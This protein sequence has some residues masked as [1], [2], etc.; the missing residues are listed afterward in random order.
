LY[1]AVYTE[2]SE[3]VCIP[4][5]TSFCD[6]SFQDVIGFRSAPTVKATLDAEFNRKT[7]V[8]MDLPSTEMAEAGMNQ[9]DCSDEVIFSPIYRYAMERTSTYIK[10]W[11]WSRTDGSVPAEVKNGATSIDTSN[12]VIFSRG[13]FPAQQLTIPSRVLRLHTF[14]MHSATLLRNLGRT[15]L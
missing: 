14:Q 6:H 5:C 13:C 1:D 9:S 4:F 12:W 3:R 8:A 10:V 11:F 2:C 15:R 7:A